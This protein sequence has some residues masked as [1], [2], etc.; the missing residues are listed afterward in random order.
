M[1]I[2]GTLVLYRQNLAAS[3]VKVTTPIALTD[4]GAPRIEEDLKGKH[5]F[6]A[7]T[8]YPTASLT[9]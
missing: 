3:K 4:T 7:A 5:F 9:Q 6:D 2:D 8:Y 1:N